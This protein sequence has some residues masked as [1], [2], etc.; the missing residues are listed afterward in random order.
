MSICG[1]KQVICG[2]RCLLGEGAVIL[3]G[4]LVGKPFILRGKSYPRYLRERE[5][6]EQCPCAPLS[7]LAT[8]CALL[9]PYEGEPNG[10]KDPAPQ[11]HKPGGWITGGGGEVPGSLG[12]WTGAGGGQVGGLAA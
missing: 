7:V 10:P 6:E 11:G 1:N 2:V 4:D 9:T 5:R 3:R 8:C 12:W